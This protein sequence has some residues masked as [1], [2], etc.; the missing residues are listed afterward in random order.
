MKENEAIEF[1][2]NLEKGMFLTV[3]IPIFRDEIKPITVM[4]AGKD[5]EGRYNFIDSG[6][7][8]LSK[9]FIEKGKVTLDK[10]FNGDEAFEIYSK[11]KFSENKK[12]IKSKGMSR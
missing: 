4:Y 3:N 11:I 12:H 5:K 9:D 1:L 10:D 2:E 8:I 7:F 6:N